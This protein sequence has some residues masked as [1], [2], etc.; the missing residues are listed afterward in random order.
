MFISYGPWSAPLA[1]SS[2]SP[3]IRKFLEAEPR[4]A[5]DEEGWL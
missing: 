5:E 3:V 4:A 2:E 1:L